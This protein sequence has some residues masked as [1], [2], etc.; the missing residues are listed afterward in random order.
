MPSKKAVIDDERSAAARVQLLELEGK[1]SNMDISQ[2]A[3]KQDLIRQYV[4]LKSRLEQY[5]REVLSSDA[6][7]S[8][9]SETPAAPQKAKERVIF[10]EPAVRRRKGRAFGVIG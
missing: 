5:E 3:E 9:Q 4:I 7:A 2:Q 1:I 6:Q 10:D 8:L